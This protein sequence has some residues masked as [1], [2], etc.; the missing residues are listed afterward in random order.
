M[1]RI[2]NLS[3]GTLSGWMRQ[4]QFSV[5]ENKRIE[6][7]VQTAREH[8]RLK[9]AVIL[10]DKKVERLKH[11]TARARWQF[12]YLRHHSLFL[13]GIALYWAEGAKTNEYCQFM[14][15]DPA[16][17][18]MM[19]RW[20]RLL[21]IPFGKL[22]FTLYSHRLFEQEHHEKYWADTLHIPLTSMGKTVYKPTP[23]TIKK[24]PLYRGCMRISCGGV[25]L[26]YKIVEW[27]KCLAGLVG[28]DPE[29]V[30][31]QSQWTHT[32]P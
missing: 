29:L 24:N 1:R 31:A 18:Q 8:G 16:I 10:H 7:R 12:S 4:V 11:C 28:C 17:I 22:R 30:I 23:H 2:P 26:F 13:V 21:G 15:S 6:S 9:V 25:E 14:N 32:R 3:K 27:K 20:F 5:E 19:I